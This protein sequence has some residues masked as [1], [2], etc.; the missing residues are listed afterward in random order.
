MLAALDAPLWLHRL[1]SSS[2]RGNSV[3]LF[4]L[5]KLPH[6]VQLKHEKDP[7]HDA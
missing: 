3:L 7:A 5:H 2:G 6:T 1:T 4:R